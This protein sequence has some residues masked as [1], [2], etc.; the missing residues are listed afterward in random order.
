MVVIHH[1]L[2]HRTGIHRM[3]IRPMD[4]HRMVTDIHRMAVSDHTNK[5]ERMT[6]GNPIVMR[7]F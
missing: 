4:T 1:M 5:K 6:V 3:A 7:S 2:I